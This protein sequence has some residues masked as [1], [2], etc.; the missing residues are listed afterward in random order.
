MDSSEPLGVASDIAVPG[1]ETAQRHDIDPSAEQRCKGILQFGEVE[2]RAAGLEV[3]Q[4]VD[5]ALPC[6]LAA[7]D[8]AEQR[9]RAT[10]VAHDECLDPVAVRLDLR[11]QR[12]ESSI[13]H[14]CQ[15]T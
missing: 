12:Q 10:L 6:L 3:D 4:E 1:L 5:V 15:D 11:S 7:G 8:R 9:N 2:Q 13:R 14:D